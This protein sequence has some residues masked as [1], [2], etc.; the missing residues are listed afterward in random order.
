MSEDLEEWAQYLKHFGR[1]AQGRVS[2]ALEGVSTLERGVAA[3]EALKKLERE[4]HTLKGEAK[5][6]KLETIAHVASCAEHALA[7]AQP[8]GNDACASALTLLRSLLELTN[9]LVAT[10][11]DESA[12][13]DQVTALSMEVERLR[14]RAGTS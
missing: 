14:A 2:R 4:L 11:P 6:L 3:P 10:M 12:H 1:L 7:A 8:P 9:G 5:L 13:R